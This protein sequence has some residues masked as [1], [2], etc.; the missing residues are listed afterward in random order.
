VVPVP[1]RASSTRFTSTAKQL[2]VVDSIL[3]R[4]YR[5]ASRSNVGGIAAATYPACRSSLRSGRGSVLHGSRFWPG[6]NTV[7]LNGRVLAPIMSSRVQ[8]RHSSARL[9]SGRG[10]TRR[11]GSLPEAAIGRPSI[12]APARPTDHRAS[13]WPAVWAA[14][15]IVKPVRPNRPARCWPATPSHETFGIS[16]QSR[17]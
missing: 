15:I 16:W 2:G 9:I 10:V 13:L 1:E 17:L 4:G 5:Q 14:R 12:C 6:I 7:L 8:L 3:R 11:V